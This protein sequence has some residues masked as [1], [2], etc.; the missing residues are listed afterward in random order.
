MVVRVITMFN[1]KRLGNIVSQ[2]ERLDMEY[3]LLEAVNAE[4]I[5]FNKK[6]IKVDFEAVAK[7][8][9]K[10]LTKGEV[11]CFLSHKKAWEEVVKSGIS[12]I[13]LEDD[14]ILEENL[15]SFMQEAKN[16]HFDMFDVI[17]LGHAKKDIRYKNK[18]NFLEPL[19]EYRNIQGFN[20]GHGFKLWTC[21]AVGYFITVEGA[22]KLLA[23]NNV[24]C[25]VADDWP[26][27][28]SQGLNVVQ[29]RPKLVWEN[30]LNLESSLEGERKTKKRNSWIDYIFHVFR[31]ARALFRHARAKKLSSGKR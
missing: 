11:A 27:Y 31:Y 20:I 13:I 25:S 23:M 14:A 2:L 7:N 6:N 30:Y 24:I 19:K 28:R 21:G 22:K 1:Q 26:L 16:K 3:E 15:A 10:Q 9:E 5:N 29:V 18:Y 12:G 8:R 4:K 17:V